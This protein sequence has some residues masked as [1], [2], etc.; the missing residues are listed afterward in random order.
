M[1]WACPHNI[2]TERVELWWQ[3]EVEREPPRQTDVCPC[4]GG[5]CAKGAATC[6]FCVGFI[7]RQEVM[8]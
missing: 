2:G 8:A 7:G 3:R 6:K 1:P 5:P 4:C